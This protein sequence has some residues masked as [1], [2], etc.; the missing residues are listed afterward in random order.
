M[1]LNA[2]NPPT[3]YT[4]LSDL[5]EDFT[6][7][8]LDPLHLGLFASHEEQSDEE[9]QEANKEENGDDDSNAVVKG[10]HVD[11]SDTDGYHPRQNNQT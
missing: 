7:K 8:G 3:I 9:E 4:S 2:P 6:V 1:V 10:Y 11:A 5:Q